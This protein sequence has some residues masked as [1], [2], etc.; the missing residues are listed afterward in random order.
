MS[1]P[2]F[3]TLEFLLV[4]SKFFR[5]PDWVVVV[6]IRASI[7]RT[8]KLYIYFFM[9]IPLLDFDL[10]TLQNKTQTK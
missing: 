6:K 7:D 10:A 2:N 5:H 8:H 3:L 9:I 1:L 4:G